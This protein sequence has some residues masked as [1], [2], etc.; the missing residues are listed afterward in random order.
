[1]NR[2]NIYKHKRS[3]SKK[4]IRLLKRLQGFAT[5]GGISPVKSTATTS[6][7]YLLLETNELGITA[8][9]MSCLNKNCVG[10]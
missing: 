1:M 6:P 10:V 7:K 2:A 3:I 8:K 4:F 9:N 5:V